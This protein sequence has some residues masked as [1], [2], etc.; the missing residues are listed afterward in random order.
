MWNKANEINAFSAKQ[1]KQ[2]KNWN[3]EWEVD[4]TLSKQKMYLSGNSEV[5]KLPGFS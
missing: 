2:T 5:Y 1:T 4:Q 3:I